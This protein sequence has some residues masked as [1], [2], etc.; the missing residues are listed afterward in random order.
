M[1]RLPRKSLSSKPG[2]PRVQPCARWASTVL[3]LRSGRSDV[4]TNQNARFFDQ[5]EGSNF[6]MLRLPRKSLSSKPGLPRVQPCARWASTVLCLRSGRSDVSTN[7]NARFFDQSEG[8]NFKNAPIAEL[9]AG[10]VQLSSKPG[11][12]G[13]STN[14]K[15]RI[16]KMAELEAGPSPST[17]MRSVGLYGALLAIRT[18]GRF[19]QSERSVFRPI[20][21]LEFLKCSDCHENR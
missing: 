4:S 18:L 8:S 5:S 11:T 12:L 9:E 21:R 20:R 2:L 6:K 13:F 19:D 10:K 14:Q 17:A 16:T 7:Q 1:L 3:C 15:A